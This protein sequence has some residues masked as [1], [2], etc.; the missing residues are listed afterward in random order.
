MT[1]YTPSGDPLTGSR[2]VSVVIRDELT[3]IATAI[4]SKQNINALT[5]VSIT[6]T[7]IPGSVPNNVSMVWEAG[8]LFLPGYYVTIVDTALPVTNNTT[9]MILSYNSTS[10]A[11]TVQV[12]A[13]NGSGTIS[14]W[15]IVTTSQSGVTLGSNTFTGFQNFSRATV[16]SAAT[17]SDIWNA[18]G[19]QIDFTGTATVTGFPAAPQAGAWRELICAGACS[20]TAGANMLISGYGSGSTMTCSA[21]DIVLVTAISTAQFR[22]H[23]FGYDGLPPKRISSNLRAYA[24]NGNGVGSSSTNVRL[25]TTTAENTLSA[26]IVHSATAGTS[27][28]VPVPG[29]YFLQARDYFTGSTPATPY[30]GISRNATSGISTSGNLSILALAIATTASMINEVSCVRYLDAND[31]IRLLNNN[32]FNGTSDTMLA[33]TLIG[34]NA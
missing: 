16:A 5:T 24:Y 13:K 32:A 25:L 31:V 22:L 11:A 9:G 30:F 18:L 4:A 12:T 8:K 21:N 34:Y 1:D 10:G 23:R 29:L 27:I 2:A 17:T 26:T 3:A 7:A 15:T 33:A 6:P 19:N 20:F 14:A 28:T